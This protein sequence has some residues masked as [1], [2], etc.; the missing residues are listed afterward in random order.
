MGERRLHGDELWGKEYV[1]TINNEQLFT[2]YG[3]IEIIHKTMYKSKN[4]KI[5]SNTQYSKSTKIYRFDKM[6]D[7]NNGQRRYEKY[8]R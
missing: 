3:Q 4:K 7:I 8:A 2:N 6:N 5:G 1:A